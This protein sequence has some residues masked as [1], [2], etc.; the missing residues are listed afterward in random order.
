[1]APRLMP[2]QLDESGAEFLKTK[3]EHMGIH[4]HLNKTASSVSGKEKVEALEFKDNS[5]L[6]A[7]MVV[8]SAGIKPRDE[9]ARDC[10]LGVGPRGGV[11]VNHKLQTSDPYIY[12]IGECALFEGM[13]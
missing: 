1:F 3:L 7:D 8:I 6:E 12:A 11:I 5:K 10:G 2:R 9:L 4:V 13:V